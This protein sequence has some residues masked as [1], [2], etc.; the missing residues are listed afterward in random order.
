MPGDLQGTR[1]HL[2]PTEPKDVEEAYRRALDVTSRGPWFP[3]NVRSQATY[4]AGNSDGNWGTERGALRI[5]QNSDDALIG[6]VMF[7]RV[8]SDVDEVVLGY[9]VYPEFRG[10]GYGSEANR[11]FAEY[12]FANRRDMN[13]ATLYIHP[14]NAAS[15]RLAERCGFSYEGRMREGWW[16]SGQWNDVLIY[17]LLRRELID[18]RA[19]HPR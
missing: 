11:L 6:S 16:D 14:D 8:V 5:V 19:P 12:L 3:H 1:V 10:Q 2:R 17:S 7:E 13:R 15:I 9:F 18:G 4:E